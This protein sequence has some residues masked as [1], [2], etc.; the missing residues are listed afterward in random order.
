MVVYTPVVATLFCSSMG[1]EWWHPFK[2]SNSLN[3]RRNGKGEKTHKVNHYGGLILPPEMQP[4]K[5]R[6]LTSPNGTSSQLCLTYLCVTL[7]QR[8]LHIDLSLSSNRNVSGQRRRSDKLSILSRH[9]TQSMNIK[10]C[11]ILHCLRYLSTHSTSCRAICASASPVSMA[12]GEA[13]LPPIGPL[14]K[15]RGCRGSKV[16]CRVPPHRCCNQLLSPNHN[17][18]NVRRQGVNKTWSDWQLGPL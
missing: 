18:M 9:C 3:L 16:V 11:S 8:S 2:M 1:F 10:S 13:V 15:R 5:A 6:Q 14:P 12:T 7:Q 4:V 17:E